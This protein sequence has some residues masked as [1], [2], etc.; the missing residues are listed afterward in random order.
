MKT[1]AT[2]TKQVLGILLLVCFGSA[3]PAPAIDAPRFRPASD[4]QPAIGR[5]LVALATDHEIEGNRTL[6]LL[7]RTY[8]GRL[9]PFAHD[10]LAGPM[11]VMV[12]RPAQARALSNDPRVL[13]VEE[14]PVASER[15]DPAPAPPPRPLAAVPKAAVTRTPNT[16]SEVTDNSWSSGTYEYDGAGNIKKIGDDIYRYDKFG[17]LARATAGTAPVATGTTPVNEQNFNFD[18]FGNLTSLTTKTTSGT[19]SSGFAVNA[20]TNQLNGVCPSGVDRCLSGIYDP[21]GSGNQVGLTQSDHFTWDPLGLMTELHDRRFERYVYDANDERIL[22]IDVTPRPSSVETHRRYT[23]RGPDNKVLRELTHTLSTN[24][25]SAAKDYV[26]RGSSLIASFSSASASDPNRHFHTDH[27]G[28]TR[29]VTD[30]DARRLA[31]HTYWPFGGEADGSERDLERMKFTGHERD[32][33]GSGFELDYM[34]ARY[35]DANLARFL[36]YDPAR[37][38]ANPRVPQ[39]WNRYSYV[40][41]NPLKAVDP[42]GKRTALV[43]GRKLDVE[44]GYVVGFGRAGSRS[45]NHVGMVVGFNRAPDGTLS[46][47][48]V[49]HLPVEGNRTAH[50]KG[51]LPDNKPHNLRINDSNSPQAGGEYWNSEKNVPLFVTPNRTWSGDFHSEDA[52]RAVVGVINQQGGLTYDQSEAGTN[53]GTRTD[54]AGAVNR[55]LDLLGGTLDGGGAEGY[56]IQDFSEMASSVPVM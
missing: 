2:V 13:W 21:A 54:C 30:G 4:I 49:E 33:A 39:S 8:G 26:Y 36:S 29:V 38:S 15:I 51:M 5:Y 50:K 17:R 16:H 28:S 9:E 41:N 20:N 53:Y 10:G 27:L 43:F 48:I 44:P 19:M 23:L 37:T 14:R 25:W 6:D 31:V 46:A 22:T 11:I 1:H 55:L 35:Y 45:A 18:P 47:T 56:T 3:M 12:M 52:V 42:N 24:T 40:M 34:H 32:G 7:A